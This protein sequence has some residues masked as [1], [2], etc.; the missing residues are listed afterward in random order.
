MKN[1]DLKRQ[2]AV[3][4]YWLSWYSCIEPAVDEIDPASSVYEM[5][6]PIGRQIAEQCA[7]SDKQAPSPG[8]CIVERIPLLGLATHLPI[9]QRDQERLL[10]CG[11]ACYRLFGPMLGQNRT[12]PI[13]M[14]PC[15]AN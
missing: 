15:A 1:R 4:D 13:R 9:C 10:L 12:L 11:L 6:A 3:R 7:A 14:L 2:N 8:D 5:A